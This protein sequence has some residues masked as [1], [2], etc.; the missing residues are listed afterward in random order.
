[1]GCGN[2]FLASNSSCPPAEALTLELYLQQVAAVRAALDLQRCHLYGQGVGGMLALK[3]AAS[4][5]G[6]VSVSVGSVAPSYE[7]LAADRRAAAA[8][9]LGAAGSQALFAADAAGGGSGALLVSKGSS[10]DAQAAWQQY[11]QQC[12]SRLP[13][14][15]DAGGGC[16]ARALQQQSQPVFAALAGSRYFEAAGALARWSVGGGGSSVDA[17]ALQ[18]VP[19]LISRGEFDEVSA[20]SAAQL[21]SALPSSGGKVLTCAGSGSFMHIGKWPCVRMCVWCGTAPGL[22]WNP[23]AGVRLSSASIISFS[24]CAVLSAVC[25]LLRLLAPAKRHTCCCP[26]T[27]GSRT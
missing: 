26:Q 22:V 4:S 6:I 20:A 9:L 19:V 5:T 12:V 16:V 8:Q 1:V 13:A 2:T 21:A 14:A 11:S 25:C 3:H 17:A 18:D 10:G 23:P 7:Q 24:L 15:G 27:P